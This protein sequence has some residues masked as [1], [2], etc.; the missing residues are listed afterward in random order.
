MAIEDK[1][2]VKVPENCS[3]AIR[4]ENISARPQIGVYRNGKLVFQNSD[5]DILETALDF[6]GSTIKVHW[7]VVI[8]EIPEDLS[9]EGWSYDVVILADGKEV[10]RFEVAVEGHQ[11]SFQK[12]QIVADEGGE[13]DEQ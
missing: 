8:A 4:F 13:S 5:P 9:E 3:L 11:N 1:G 6:D 12:C 2:I 7:V 10:K